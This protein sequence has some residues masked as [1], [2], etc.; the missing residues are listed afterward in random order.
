M[1]ILVLPIDGFC[2]RCNNQMTTREFKDTLDNLLKPHGFKKKGNEWTVETAELLKSID[3]QKSNFSHLYYLNY[4]YNFKDLVYDGTI[5]HVCNRLG[6]Q[7]THVNKRI[8]ET[9]DLG[10]SID[11]LTRTKHLSDIINHI[12][13][14]EINS[15]NTKADLVNSLKKRPTLNDIPARVKEYLNI[16][17]E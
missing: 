8:Q 11:D 14:P 4:G 3:L 15:T 2:V 13:L 6:A 16:K 12:I 17:A 1:G 5:H 7:D 10:N 9:F